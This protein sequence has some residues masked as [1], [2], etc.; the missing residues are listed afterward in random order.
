MP[1]KARKTTARSAPPAKTKGRPRGKGVSKQRILEIATKMFADQGFAALSMR[2]IAAA[3]DLNVPSIYHFF[4][5]KEHLYQSCCTREFAAVAATLRAHLQSAGG[6]KAR[7]KGF[8]VGLCEALLESREWRRL[9][10][11]EIIMRDESRHFDALSTDYFLPEF[12][13]LVEEIALLEGKRD[14]AE[15]A[16]SIYALTF[17]L[18]LLRRTFEVAG[19]TQARSFSPARLAQRVLDNVLPAQSWDRTG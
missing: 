3:S 6:P 9:L 13:L 5:G 16:L 14:A 12:R 18:V 11:Q 10:L 4:E 19:V 15:H 7:I 8:T 17:G 2:D 1:I